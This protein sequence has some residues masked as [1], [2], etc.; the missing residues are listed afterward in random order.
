[1]E[2]DRESHPIR[3]AKP[4]QSGGELFDLGRGQEQDRGREQLGQLK[5]AP[6]AEDQRGAAQMEQRKVNQR[7]PLAVENHPRERGE[8]NDQDEEPAQPVEVGPRSRDLRQRE[9]QQPQRQQRQRMVDPV[10]RPEHHEQRENLDRRMEPMDEG[11]AV[12]I[13]ED[14]HQPCARSQAASSSGVSA[15]APKRRASSVTSG[16]R[17]DEEAS[18]SSRVKNSR[19]PPSYSLRP[20]RISTT[21]RAYSA[22]NHGVCVMITIAIPSRLSRLIRPIMRR[23][24]R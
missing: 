13:Q 21:R 17:K 8:E 4:R 5:P 10:H 23:C 2:R 14:R 11:A 1:G 12:D 15:T 22:T 20:R 24:S 6:E 7:R 3:N 16:G 9:H 19:T 18:S